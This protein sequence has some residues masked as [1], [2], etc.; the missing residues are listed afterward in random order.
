M[1]YMFKIGLISAILSFSSLTIISNVAYASNETNAQELTTEQI[2]KQAHVKIGL[3]G[4]VCDFCALA[5]NKTFAKNSSVK[6]SYVDLDSKEMRVVFHGEQRLD[7][8]ILTEMV[9]DAG[10]NVTEIV[11]LDGQ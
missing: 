1:I 10:Y 3:S 6:A 9:K 4:L 8:H 5:L 11:H 7:D 2:I